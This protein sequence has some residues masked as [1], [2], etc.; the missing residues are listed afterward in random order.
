M[1]PDAGTYEVRYVQ[2]QDFVVL[3]KQTIN[4]TPV[5]ATLS[6]PDHGTADSTIEVSWTGPDYPADYISIN[7]P[8]VISTHHSHVSHAYTED[9]SPLTL[10]LPEQ[11]GTYEIR[12]VQEQGFRVLARQIITVTAQ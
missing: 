2:N 1:P 5:T 10:Q 4:L 12:Y 11:P 3:A 9:G 8:D 7:A 6:A